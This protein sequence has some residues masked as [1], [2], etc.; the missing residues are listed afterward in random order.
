MITT[1]TPDQIP[2][3]VSDGSFKH[4]C[5][6]G[7]GKNYGGFN[8]DP[9]V[10][11]TK[12]AEIK[13]LIQKNP[14]ENFVIN[15]KMNINGDI[16]Q[17][18]INTGNLSEHQ[19]TP[20]PVIYQHTSELEKFQT[21][22]A[23]KKQLERINELE[24]E[25]EIL[26]M[27]TMYESQLNEKPVKNQ[28]QGFAESMIPI[29]VPMFDRFM[30]LQNRKLN[31]QEKKPVLSSQPIT[32][33]YRP[34]PSIDSESFQM[35][36]TWIDGLN[37]LQ[38]QREMMYVKKFNPDVYQYLTDEDQEQDQEQEQNTQSNQQDNEN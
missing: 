26:K 5:L 15:C 37:D 38:F 24:K 21:L 36:I 16:W 27:K 8:K 30:D 4:I 32:K 22:D 6:L 19:S 12:I 7:K 28:I 1:I 9:K 3:I 25:I 31:Q 23:Y 18:Q 35:Y 13:K 14:E 20:S 11:K 33:P 29:V 10:I 2:Q 17:Y 34:I